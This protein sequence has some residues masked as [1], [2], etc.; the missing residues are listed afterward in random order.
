RGATRPPRTPQAVTMPP[1]RFSPAVPF[2]KNKLPNRRVNL[3]REHPRPLLFESSSKRRRLNGGR[4][5]RRHVRPHYAVADVIELYRRRN[6]L[7]LTKNC[8]PGRSRVCHAS[9]R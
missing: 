4:V 1:R 8:H 9:F 2:Y 6:W 3:H 5:L 7:I